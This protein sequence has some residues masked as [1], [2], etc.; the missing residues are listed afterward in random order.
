MVDPAVPEPEVEVQGGC[1][2]Y[3]FRREC[4]ELFKLAWPLVGTSCRLFIALGKERGDG[5]FV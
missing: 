2:P 4:K 3:G 1:F 5:G